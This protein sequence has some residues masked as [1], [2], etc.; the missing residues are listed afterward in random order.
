MTRELICIICPKGCR[1]TAT[2]CEGQA[3]VTGNA[4]ARGEAYAASELLHPMRTVTATMRVA[5]REYAMVPVKTAAPVP[6]EEMMAVM[7]ALRAQTVQAPIQM[8]QVLLSDVCG[9]DI[10]ATGQL[11]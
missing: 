2:V 11:D 7:A 5:N 10:I 8:G 1:L 9:T 3:A 4:C 6:K